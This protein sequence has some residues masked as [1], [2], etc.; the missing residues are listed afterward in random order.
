[1]AIIL[2][3]PPPPRSA[4]R[5]E[6]GDVPG[7]VSQL[8]S[9]P[10]LAAAVAGVARIQGLR[11]GK[12][13]V[14]RLR[15][16]F[17]RQSLVHRPVSMILKQFSDRR[18]CQ[19][20]HHNT[21]PFPACRWWL[22]VVT[23]ALLSADLCGQTIEADS[24]LIRLIDQ[25]DVPARAIG[26]L[27][28]I[29]TSEGKVVLKG[30]LLAQIDDTEA[31]LD[32]QRAEMEVAIARQQ[33]TDDVAIRSAKKSSDYARAHYERL[34]RAEQSQ[35]RS[36]SESEL[37][38]ARLDAEQ[39]VLEMERAQSEHELA[40]L[41]EKL[42]ASDSEVAKRNVE[43]RKI[44]APLDGVVVSVLNQPG[45]WV[46][47]GDKIFRI[48]RTNRLRAEGFVAAADVREDLRGATVTLWPE[49]AESASETFSGKIVFVSP[50]IDPVN[51]QVRVWAEVENPAGRLRPGIRAKM[52]IQT[53]RSR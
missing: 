27:A 33:A 37:E 48:V 49:L 39:A 53:R 28:E 31:R 25:V 43:V 52:T 34:R 41:K 46:K 26:A 20:G 35:P 23:V 8:I 29:H 51:G 24:V 16:R 2:M 11:I 12:P 30:Q 18:R 7:S 50:E 3:R 13:E 6:S 14:W 40:N 10:D 5:P 17:T 38:K 21:F 45:E 32:Q 4:P 15:L 1:M 9:W 42:S 22:A 47:P 19:F 44:M 36:V